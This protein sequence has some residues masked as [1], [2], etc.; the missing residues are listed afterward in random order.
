MKIIVL[1]DSFKGTLSSEEFCKIAEKII[2]SALAAEVIAFP[3][4]D[5]GE[6]SVDCLVKLTNGKTISTKVTDGNLFKKNAL[7]GYGG[8][9]AFIAVSESSGLPQTLIKDPGITTTKGM[10]EQI[11]QAKHLGKKKIVLGLGGS[12]TN[13]GGAGLVCALGGKFFDK[14]GTEFLPTGETLCKIEK[15]DLTEFNKNIE[16]MEFVGMCDVKNPLLGISGCTYVYAPQKGAKK[17]ERLDELE[18]NM[19]HF[20]SVSSF[21]GVDPMTP[22]TGAAGGLG[23]CVL[24]FLKGKLISGIDYILDK[25]DF[26][27]IAADADYVFTGEG[28]FDPT[29]LSGKVVSGIKKRAEKLGAKIVVFCGA[30]TPQE[31]Y[32]VKP[33]NDPT[34]SL[35]ENMQKT[36][37]NLEKTIKDFCLS[38]Q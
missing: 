15:I 21:L 5:G 17:K 13:D 7:L 9:T 8:D 32:I 6:G 18:D 16:G 4:C 27:K 25:I 12:S 36:A 35:A 1:P 2:P 28:K 24:A 30:G 11:L 3:V 38:L 31:G 20:A 23:Y 33:I 19:K 29:S 14:D 37:E 26:E 22:G 10:G 34:L